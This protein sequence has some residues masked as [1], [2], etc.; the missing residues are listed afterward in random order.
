MDTNKLIE[1]IF[2]ELL[3]EVRANKDLQDRITRLFEKQVKRVDKPLKRHHRRKPGP[4]DPMTVHRD[5]PEELGP[6]L[7]ALDV[8][9]LKNIVAEH[10]MDRSKLAMKWKS[11]ERLVDLIMT[12]V[13]S[14]AQKGDVF[15]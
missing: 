15:R 2:S 4:F 3:K 14:R 8:E 11:K 9:E 5:Q 1:A 12:K 6:R 10:G 13:K 7:E